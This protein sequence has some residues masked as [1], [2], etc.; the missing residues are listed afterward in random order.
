MWEM[1]GVLQTLQKERVC[2]MDVQTSL[3]VQVLSLTIIT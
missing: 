2:S 1:I 3:V